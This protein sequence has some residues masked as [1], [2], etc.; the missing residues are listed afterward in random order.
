MGIN[1]DFVHQQRVDRCLRACR[2]GSSTYISSAT[3]PGLPANA[4]GFPVICQ[5]QSAGDFVVGQVDVMD[6]FYRMELPAELRRYFG[7]RRVRVSLRYKAR[8]PAGRSDVDASDG[9]AA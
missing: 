1:A 4:C 6:A 3:P 7:M 5:I 8:H 9:S 2:C